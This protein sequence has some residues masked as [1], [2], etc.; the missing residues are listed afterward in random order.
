MTK[1]AYIYKIAQKTVGDKIEAKL[2]S[3]NVLEMNP[4]STSPK[5]QVFKDISPSNGSVIWT[6]MLYLEDLADDSQTILKTMML[7]AAKALEHFL[8]ENINKGFS[9]DSPIFP[10]ASHAND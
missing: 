8:L 10:S 5:T 3:I 7:P 2:I 6:V 9:L 1:T 4:T